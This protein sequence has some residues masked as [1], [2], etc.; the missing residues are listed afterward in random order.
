MVD[1]N[2]FSRRTI[3]FPY[4]GNQIL[5]G[6]K[7]KGFGRGKYNG[8]GGKFDAQKGDNIIEDTAVRELMEESSLKASVSDLEKRAVIDFIFPA[9]SSYNQR[10]HVYFLKKFEGNPEM[11]EEMDPGWFSSHDIP[12]TKMW[13]SDKLWLPQLLEGKKFYATFFWKDDNE[14]VAKYSIDYTTKLD[15]W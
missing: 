11:T 2:Q 5:L 13:D 8:F 1:T 4:A 15:E 14:T 12:Y 6:F 9:K 10:V 3:C 7:L